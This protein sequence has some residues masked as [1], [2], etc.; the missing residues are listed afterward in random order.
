MCSAGLPAQSSHIPPA[1]ES[2]ILDYQSI[3][4]QPGYY[5]NEVP[6]VKSNRRR[7]TQAVQH[8]D[9]GLGIVILIPMSI[10]P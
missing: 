2:L 1:I 6:A 8:P 7:L 9:S 3:N 5:P 10:A 4:A